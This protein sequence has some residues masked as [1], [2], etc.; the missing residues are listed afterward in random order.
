M[1][2]KL[3][4]RGVYYILYLACILSPSWI[5]SYPDL[6]PFIDHPLSFD[7][8][9]L[10]RFCFF[11]VLSA[12][13]GLMAAWKLGRQNTQILYDERIFPLLFLVLL[14]LWSLLSALA[15]GKLGV[16]F[17]GAYTRYNG[18]FSYLMYALIVGSLWLL[19][20][21][22]EQGRKLIFALLLGSL[23]VCLLAYI[24]AVG[25]DP[26]GWTAGFGG[27]AGSSFG[28][29][30]MLGPYQV[31][32]ASI[33]WAGLRESR[34]QTKWW[35]KQFFLACFVALLLMM[36]C[37]YNRSSWFALMAGVLVIELMRL[38]QRPSFTHRNQNTPR[39]EINRALTLAIPCCF[40]LIAA[41]DYLLH[42]DNSLIMR[43]LS[44][45]SPEEW[46]HSSRLAIWDASLHA[47]ASRPTLGWGADNFEGLFAQYFTLALAQ[48]YPRPDILI[49]SPHNIFLQHA[50]G[51]G[52]VQLILYLCF[53]LSFFHLC[54]KSG[55]ALLVGTSL[56]YLIQIS[57]V[58]TS[59][60]NQVYFFI[61]VGIA[62]GFTKTAAQK[63][64]KTPQHYRKPQHT[65][66]KRYAVCLCAATLAV[67]SLAMLP[68]A[69]KLSAAD[70][71]YMQARNSRGVQRMQA[72]H[73]ALQ[74][75]PYNIIYQWKYLDKLF[76][77]NS[78]DPNVELVLSEGDKALAY[79]PDSNLVQSSYFAGLLDILELN[80]QSL[81]EKER[82]RIIDK[83]AFLEQKL[84]VH[85]RHYP[86]ASYL[87]ARYF[88]VTHHFEHAKTLAQQAFEQAN[89]NYPK[90]HELVVKA[91]A[92]LSKTKRGRQ[93]V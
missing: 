35:H 46:I 78:L 56:A 83:A 10:A 67:G 11:I 20:L 22:P 4:E 71:F 38:V 91:Q 61:M 32:C 88:Y 16:S 87:R 14:A 18:V 89:E 3:I 52:A 2:D 50:L 43:L 40:I 68:L 28:N 15:N 44:L 27:R 66:R 13:L 5:T 45:L 75:N 58:P 80:T 76:S 69:Y 51:G 30:N 1:N 39:S 74:L 34:L 90:A 92:K 73:K 12:I 21:K 62:L 19:G 7:P 63:E 82:Q 36:F 77:E 29:P 54:L 42:Q 57:A 81:S 85:A 48:S 70:Y 86:Y 33:A 6:L 25:H 55:S 65:K 9:T 47:L 17:I 79:L 93:T 41:V 64:L 37:S 23:P 26:F 8:T 72:F 49:D 60:S 24:Q 84:A 53:L 59:P 31:L